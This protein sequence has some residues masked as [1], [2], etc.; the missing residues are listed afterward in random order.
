MTERE[1]RNLRIGDEVKDLKVRK[2]FTEKAIGRVYENDGKIVKIKF[3]ERTDW[4]PSQMVYKHYR[5]V[6]SGLTFN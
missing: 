6:D 2:G 3:C 4:M 1:G 5:K